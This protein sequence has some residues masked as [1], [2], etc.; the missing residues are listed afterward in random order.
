MIRTEVVNNIVVDPCDIKDTIQ[1][2]QEEEEEDL[3]IEGGH[4]GE[5]DWYIGHYLTYPL[6][7]RESLTRTI[8]TGGR[9]SSKQVTHF[10]YV[11]K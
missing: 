1:Q 11:E 3:L 7:Q 5:R 6:I 9:Q 4:Y 10:L 8:S 2:I